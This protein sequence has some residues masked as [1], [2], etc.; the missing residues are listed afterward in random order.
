MIPY[1]DPI[2]DNV[3]KGLCIMCNAPIHTKGK[4]TCSQECHEKFI[5]LGEKKFGIT[6]SVVDIET[7]IS[8]AIPTR[9]IIEKG[10]KWEDLTKY[11]VRNGE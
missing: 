2:F 9:D 8:Y 4:I 10:L 1:I 6:K 3:A 5:E 11:P 7:G